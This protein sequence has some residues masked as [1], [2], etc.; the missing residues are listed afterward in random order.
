MIQRIKNNAFAR[1]SA[2]LFAGSMIGNAIGYIFHFVIGR[3][4][5]IP[6]YGE[7]ESLIS[8]I[9]IISVPSGA[10][11]MA[12]TKFSAGS[13]AENDPSG[14]HEILSYFNKKI[15]KYGLPLFL[16]ALLI[17]PLVKS[18]LKIE[19][20]WPIIIVWIMMYF[21]FFSATTGG[22]LNGWQKF[23]E[24]SFAGVFG[25]VAKL[26]TAIAFVKIGFAAGGVVGG[27]AL[28]MLASYLL[29]LH[30]L[31]FIL[32]KKNKAKDYISKID[33]G[34]V[35]KYIIP[36]FVGNLAITI[37]SNADMILAKHNLSLDLA[38]G[39]GALTV[40]SKIIFFGTGIIAT[41][42][43]SMS[44][45]E[46]HKKNASTKTLKHAILLM[47]V[48]G[49]GAVAVYAL[50]PKLILS[51][52]FGSKYHEVSGYLVWFAVSVTLFS[53]VNLI[54]QY[55]LSI[56]KTKISYVLLFISIL[57]VLSVAL[58][59]HSISAII[60]IMAISQILAIISG[61]FMLLTSL[62]GVK[63]YAR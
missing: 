42:L 58:F 31:K 9:A 55:L 22:I 43:F 20:I 51:L 62:K 49:L 60:G 12:A 18:Y 24:A 61:I 16:L 8:L 26:I 19:S 59:G 47:S 44:S 11:T 15:F 23:K 52:L 3:M 45:E 25:A 53:F 32:E 7:V 33:F 40:V 13:K 35:K 46:H 56:H 37:L 6:V 2:I 57:A 1:N 21:S 27:F 29:S 50:F 17:S 38:G 5:S 39:Y 63:S 48:L 14:S 4:V 54:F 30:Y 36:V 28:G 41:V 10:L 34:S